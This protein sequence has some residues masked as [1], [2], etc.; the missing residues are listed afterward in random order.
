[1]SG[2]V[3]P[4][5][6]RVEAAGQ[7]PASVGESP[8]WRVAEQA[9]YW[10]DIP[11]QKIV[12]LRLET[13]ERTE[14]QLPEKVACIAF[15][16]R[17]TVLAGCETALFA[18]TLTEDAPRGEAMKVT[19]RKLAAPLFDFDDMRFNDGRC[20][21]QGRFWSGTMVQDMAAANPA[22]ALYRFDER[23]VLSAPV[24]DALITQNGLAWSPDGT[25]MYL[26]DSHPLRRQIWAFD[27]DIEAG[28][29][30]N[31]RVFADLHD[32]AGRPDGAA[33]DADGCYWI[34]ANDAGLLLRF[35][36]QGKLDRQIAVPA[37][38]PAMCAFGGRD[39]DTLFVTSI[40][41]ATGASEHDGHLFAVRPG[42]TGLPEPEYAGEL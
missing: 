2:M 12:R 34:C 21:R 1:M 3:N 26:S 6:E 36:P 23:G 41:P 16:H 27:Y 9:L 28:V 24:V 18:V 38:K 14:W 32:Y 5:V 31:R 39:L 33:V 8:V 40:R 19:G 22:G 29:P 7:A 42:V 4:R 17:G 37:V 20:D 25:T 30:R 10:V 15:D 11:A 35:T 13:A